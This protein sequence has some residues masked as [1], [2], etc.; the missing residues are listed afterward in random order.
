M[1][2]SRCRSEE[3]VSEFWVLLQWFYNFEFLCF[4]ISE[5]SAVNEC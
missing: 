3:S 1:F 2:H 4:L 5:L